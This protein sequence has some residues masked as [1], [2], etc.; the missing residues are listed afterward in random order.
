M[1]Q[2]K[3]IIKTKNIKLGKL[4]AGPYIPKGSKII[5]T[6][7]RRGYDTGA[8]LILASGIEVQYNAGIIRSL[9]KR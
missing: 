4:Y 9:P 2:F 6:V 1:R 5:G 7:T 8:L 3:N